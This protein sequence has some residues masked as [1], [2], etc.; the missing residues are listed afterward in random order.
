MRNRRIRIGLGVIGIFGCLAASGA[1]VDASPEVRAEWAALY[2]RARSGDTAALLE[3]GDRLSAGRDVKSDPVKAMEF[4]ADAA[5][6]GN[7]T[8]LCRIADGLLRGNGP[9]GIP[10]EA[11]I[12]LLKRAAEAGRLSAMRAMGRLYAEGRY[13]ERDAAEATRWL[14]LCVKQNDPEALA[15]LAWHTEQGFGVARDPERAVALYRSAAEL[16]FAE[17]WNNLG[18]CLAEGI[19]APKDRVEAYRCFRRAA[20]AG[21]AGAERNAARIEQQAGWVERR[22]M[23][24]SAESTPVPPKP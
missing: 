22:R 3:L 15:R 12:R 7:D 19:G 6:R 14:A 8:A 11:G 18:I 16:G 5:L 17:A 24:R 20:A 4:W 2:D 13:V 1:D 23:R 9:D 21:V 10:P